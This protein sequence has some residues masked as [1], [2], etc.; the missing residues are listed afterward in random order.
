MSELTEQSLKKMKVPELKE[1][2][3]ARKLK[4][5]GKKEELILRLLQAEKDGV[6]PSADDESK[7]Q[8]KRKAENEVPTIKAD[9]KKKKPDVVPKKQEY[10][11]EDESEED[12]GSGSKDDYKQPVE[13]GDVDDEDPDEEDLDASEEELQKPL[14]SSGWNE[15]LEEEFKKDY[16]KNVCKTVAKERKSNLVYPAK[17][18][19][20]NAFNLTPLDE[21]KV[22]I[23]GQDPYFNPGQA[24]GLCFSVLRGVRIPPS[25]KR[26]YAALKNTIPGFKIPSHGCLEEWASRGVLMLN[27]T[28]TVRKGKAKS[29]EKF[30]WQTFT[31][32]V[33]KI[34][35]KRKKGIIF[36]L[37]GA[38]AQKKG[39]MINHNEQF[40]LTY[41]HPSPLARTPWD[42]DH[43]VRANE[44]LKEQGKEPIDWTLS[45]K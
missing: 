15:A 45:P 35:C 14:T 28:L 37:W 21:V 31:D 10:D 25:L 33:S 34:L 17:K 12:E 27:A 44:I 40:V 23:I 30:G 7:S 29:H 1:L 41:A 19:V 24:H 2:L 3:K 18:L 5:S 32:N 6:A 13:G 36:F 16:Y 22:V 4:V 8:T 43:F 42:C 20:F 26:I 38:F 9:T 11:D 39:K